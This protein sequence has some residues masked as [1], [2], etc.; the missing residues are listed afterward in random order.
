VSKVRPV[1]ISHDVCVAIAVTIAGGACEGVNAPVWASTHPETVPSGR[2]QNTTHRSFPSVDPITVCPF[3]T[4]PGQC[5][6]APG[7]CGSC[8]DV[9]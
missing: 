4:H 5:S 6:V 9:D 3:D 1:T 2:S 8:P 7:H